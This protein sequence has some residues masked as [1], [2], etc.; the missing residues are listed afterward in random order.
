MAC[1]DELGIFLEPIQGFY[2]PGKKWCSIFAKLTQ[3]FISSE[4]HNV[5]INIYMTLP[6]WFLCD[7]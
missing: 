1:I 4:R 6:I 5:Q 2:F 7:R 3:V